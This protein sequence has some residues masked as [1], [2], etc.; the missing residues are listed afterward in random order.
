MTHKNVDVDVDEGC[1][2]RWNSIRFQAVINSLFHFSTAPVLEFFAII[3]V[4]VD[5]NMIKNTY[6]FIWEIPWNL[7]V[8]LPLRNIETYRSICTNSTVHVMSITIHWL[9]T[10]CLLHAACRTFALSVITIFSTLRSLL[11]YKGIAI[12]FC[13][14]F[15][16]NFFVYIESEKISLNQCLICYFVITIV[17][18]V[19]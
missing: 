4:V 2:Y 15:V 3:A 17:Q 5:L 19:P 14:H 18:Y 7:E 16:I 9:D 13:V 10:C 8:H 12:L 6:M 1:L 11:L